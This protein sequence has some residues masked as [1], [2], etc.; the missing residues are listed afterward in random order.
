[1]RINQIVEKDLDAKMDKNVEVLI[2]I[3]SYNNEQYILESINSVLCQKT[4][5]KINVQVYDDCS[6]DQTV[7]K[8]TNTYGD[9]VTVHQNQKNEGFCVN[10]YKALK[11]CEAD[12]FYTLAGD[13][14][15]SSDDVIEK[16]VDYLEENSNYMSA[17][18]WN[19]VIDKN[20]DAYFEHKNLNKE[21][22]FEEYML[23]KKPYCID[24]M[25]RN[26]WSKTKEDFSYLTQGA[27]NNE[28]ILFWT[29]TLE[30]GKKAILQKYIYTYR[31]IREENGM[32]YNSQNTNFSCF[33][34]NYKNIVL[35][36]TKR[37]YCYK[38]IL[39]QSVYTALINEY[40]N[41]RIG[42]AFK[43]IF[44]LRPLDLLLCA[45]CI[46][47]VHLRRGDLPRYLKRKIVR[48]IE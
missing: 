6:T 10:L 26:F 7:L 9:L 17:S 13:D 38:G 18:G 12:Y 36:E 25:I 29:F 30:K 44:S 24:G 42:V 35:M 37:D 41:G 21:F 48:S 46:P 34:D 3:H 39:V 28:E 32:N 11:A 47:I 22:S 43:I 5:Y 8:V 20:G 23:G 2:C 1:M 4:K 16:L 27:R 19:R 33:M 31:Y 15:F 14:F 40:L 45:L